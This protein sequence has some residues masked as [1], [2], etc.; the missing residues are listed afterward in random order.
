MGGGVRGKW[1]LCYQI[2]INVNPLGWGW[3][4]PNLTQTK[5]HLCDNLY[6]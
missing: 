5:F 4:K 1:M 3:E 2:K 6:L